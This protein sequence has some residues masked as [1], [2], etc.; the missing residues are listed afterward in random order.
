[1]A[2]SAEL[3][4]WAFVRKLVHTET[5]LTGG[6]VGHQAGQSYV[7]DWNSAVFGP[8][9]AGESEWASRFDDTLA[10]NIPM[11]SDAALDHTGVSEVD[12]G[13]TVLY[14]EGV[15]VGETKLPGQ[16]QFQVPPELA[17]Y[18]LETQARRTDVSEFSSRISCVWTF[19]SVHPPDPDP[20]PKEPKDKGGNALPLMSVRFAPQNLNLRN[21]IRPGTANVPVTVQKPNGAPEATVTGL[22]VDVS[23]ND[24]RTW[25]PAQVTREPDS[26]TA[27]V[28]IDHPRS[29]A[30]VSLRARAVDSTGNTAEQ[31]IIRA[32]GIR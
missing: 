11:Y 19:T 22:T 16:G 32:Y 21:E 17:A 13:I 10:V 2:W 25:Q 23:F 26:G 20:D 5:I 18:R 29:A 8:G 24:G 12:S 1:L 27:T 15:K 9:F 28:R 4:Q 14:R 6:T 3:Q 31:T 30:F 7:E